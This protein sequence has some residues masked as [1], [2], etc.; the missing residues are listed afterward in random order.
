M[1]YL[2]TKEIMV[3]IYGAH[4]R[5]HADPCGPSQTVIVAGLDMQKRGGG[6]SEK[7]ERQGSGDKRYWG[8]MKSEEK[9]TKRNRRERS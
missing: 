1:I 8:A 2:K 9:E 4:N 6:E 7:K 3:V 5:G